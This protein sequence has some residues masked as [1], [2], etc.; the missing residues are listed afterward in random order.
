[1][2]VLAYEFCCFYDFGFL[3]KSFDSED[4]SLFREELMFFIFVI[5][6]KGI[7]RNK[8]KICR[9]YGKILH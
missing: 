7:Y 2:L 4:S 1:M 8:Q 5:I 6:F 9:F 3:T